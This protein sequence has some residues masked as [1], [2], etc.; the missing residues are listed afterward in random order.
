MRTVKRN[1]FLSGVC[2]VLGGV[3]LWA[4]TARADVTSDR[5]AA[6]LVFPKLIWDTVGRFNWNGIPVDTEIQVTNVSN[7]A[8]NLRCFYVNA[9]SHCSNSPQDICFT[10]TD[11]Q[12]FGRG[13]LC[14]DGWIE[15]DFEFSLSPRQPI[16]WRISEGLPDLPLAGGSAPLVN[17]GSIPAVSEDPFYGEL[18]CVAVDENNAPVDRNDLKGEATIVAA[19]SD[20]IDARGYNAVGIQAITNDGDNTLILGGDQPEYNGCPSVLILDHF[21]DDAIEPISSQYVKTHLTLVPCSENFQLQDIALFDTVVQFLVFNEFEQRFSASRSVRCFEEFEL[22]HLDN[23]LDRSLF[24][25]NPASDSCQRSIFSAFVSG[26]L[27]GQTRIRG[28]DDGSPD[29]G[30]GLIGVAEEFYRTAAGNLRTVRS[31]DAFNL[32]MAGNRPTAD[33]IQLP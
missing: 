11:C 9:N 18:K 21:F 2:A 15:T 16:V 3:F 5:P 25:T 8:I 4:G 33:I 22:C 17:T 28:V 29:H 7:Q 24:D 19:S 27:T 20:A 13:G 31:S 30:N 26:T 14:F 10:N 12:Q 32:D 1:P 6:I 23:K